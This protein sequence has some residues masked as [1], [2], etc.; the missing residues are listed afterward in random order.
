MSDTGRFGGERPQWPSLRGEPAATTPGGTGPVDPAVP[1][2]PVPAAPVPPAPV[3]A[4]PAAAAPDRRSRR[5]AAADATAPDAP[6]DPAARTEALARAEAALAAGDAGA[7]SAALERADAALVAA[8]PTGAA[9][10][11][12]ADAPGAGSAA[13]DAPP[14]RGRRRVVIA[15]VVAGVLVL[16][17][18]G[19][20]YLLTRDDGGGTV[21]ARPDV[22]LP[23]P[24]ATAAPVA[25]AATTPF[26]TALPVTVLQYALQTSA[27]DAGWLALNAVEAYTETYT[28]GAAGTVTV[29][30]GQWETPAEAAAVLTSL[31]AALPA[32]PAAETAADPSADPAATSAAAA[33]SVLASGEV[34]VGGQPTG[35]VTVVDAGDGT[36]VAV[37]SNGTTVFRVTGP[38]A[39][40]ANLYA[41]YPL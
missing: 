38:A 40:I 7:R 21:A 8:E 41:A 3:P 17:G 34:L 39:D 12:T 23:S 15:S 37:W 4:A 30:A 2:A 1:P 20:A 25:R 5:Y 33:P 9:D 10:Q 35:A 31:A 36:G 28:D 13:E 29:Q 22:V 6:V 18:G 14:A 16:G 11:G 24:T 19:A 27:E 32:V 26:A